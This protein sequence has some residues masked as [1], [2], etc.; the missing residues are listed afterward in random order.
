[1]FG[2]PQLSSQ[3]LGKALATATITLNLLQRSRINPRLSDYAQLNGHYDS[4]RASMAPPGT[5]VIAH[6]KTDQRASW[7]PPGVD[8]WYIGLALDHYQCYIVHISDTISDRVVD[9]LE[10]SPAHITIPRTA[11]KDM[12]K[13]MA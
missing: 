13:I 1:M 11:S 9:T 2:G 3:T 6:K 12:A 10:F 8:G 4:N 5:R 7:A